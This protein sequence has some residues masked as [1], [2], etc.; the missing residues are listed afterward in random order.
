[1]AQNTASTRR[2]KAFKARYNTYYNGHQAYLEGMSAKRTG[3]KDNYLQPLPLLM[4]GNEN[5]RKLGSGNFETAITKCE[6]TIQIYSIRKK[7]VF[8]RGQTEGEREESQ[9]TNRIQSFPEKCV[10]T[11]GNVPTTER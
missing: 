4:V 10:V 6:K 3:V 5:A 9:A 7:P 11:F 1:M 8:K 2:W